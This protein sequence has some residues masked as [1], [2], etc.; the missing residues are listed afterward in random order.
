MIG[1]QES[2]TAIVEILVHIL[3]LTSAEIATV[4]CRATQG[5]AADWLV[6]TFVIHIFKLS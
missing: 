1:W 4:E 3:I 6:S 5:V 2:F